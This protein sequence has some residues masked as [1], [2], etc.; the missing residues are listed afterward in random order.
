MSNIGQGNSGLGVFA[1]GDA[2]TPAMMQFDGST[3][4]YSATF[5]PSGNKTTTVLRF[6]KTSFTGGAGQYIAHVE[7][8]A[9]RDRVAIAAF[10][11]DHANANVRDRI[12]FLVYN[13][14]GTIICYLATL[15][16]YLDGN[17]HTLMASFDGDAGTAQFIIDGVDADDTG[18]VSRVSPTTGTLSTTA[19]TPI[20]IG[21]FVSALNFYGGQVG[22]AGYRDAYLTNWS[23]FMQADG[24][25]KALDET[26]WTE[27]GAQPLFWHEAG[28]M[29]ENL[30]SEG[31]MTKNGTINVGKGGNY[32]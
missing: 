7:S 15:A 27:W 1:G 13:S 26:T 5:N 25:P 2:H 10:A 23:D 6:N 17:N 12:V 9:S 21:A 3:G 24:S 19:S 18:W 31:A 30:G 4:Y 14:T 8:A 11:S 22:F 20:T 16:A 32:V 29:D 28:K